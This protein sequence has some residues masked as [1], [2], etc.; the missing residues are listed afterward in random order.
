MIEDAGDGR[1]RVFWPRQPGFGGQDP[2]R[3]DR[4]HVVPISAQHVDKFLRVVLPNDNSNAR[5]LR[6]APSSG[7]GVLVTCAACAQLHPEW[8]PFKLERRFKHFKRFHKRAVQVR[9]MPP[10]EHAGPPEE[11]TLKDSGAS[12]LRRLKFSSQPHVSLPVPASGDV[13]TEVVLISSNKTNLPRDCRVMFDCAEAPIIRHFPNNLGLIVKAPP[14]LND[15]TVDVR[16]MHGDVCISGN[17][18]GSPLKWTYKTHLTD[19]SSK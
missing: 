2:G 15:V 11:A 14:C 4:A 16:V 12:Q 17:P 9:A 3:F 19:V 5:H 8:N 6:L 13:G 10:M 7:D 18:D 1:G